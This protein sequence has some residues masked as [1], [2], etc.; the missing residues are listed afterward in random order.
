MT[1]SLEESMKWCAM[2][3]GFAEGFQSRTTRRATLNI[4]LAKCGRGKVMM[5]DSMDNLKHILDKLCRRVLE[6]ALMDCERKRLDQP[7]CW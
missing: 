5:Q 4:E 1:L 7:M 6:M 3:H 2:K